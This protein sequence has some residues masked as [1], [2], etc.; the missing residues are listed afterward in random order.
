MVAELDSVIDNLNPYHELTVITERGAE[1]LVA[2]LKKIRTP[3]KILAFTALNGRHHA[4]IIGDHRI[5]KKRRGRPPK[6]KG[7]DN[8]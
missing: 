3:F 6:K 1:E 4:Y 5:N 7:L 2:R 8:G